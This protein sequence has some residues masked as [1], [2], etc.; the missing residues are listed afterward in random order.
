MLK[1]MSAQGQPMGNCSTQSGGVDDEPAG[2]AGPPSRDGELSTGAA[3]A[4]SHDP[5]EPGMQ[6]TVSAA[7]GGI[8]SADAYAGARQR[9]L[10]T[11][12][13][14]RS[15]SASPINGD[16]FAFQLPPSHQPHSP[17]PALIPPKTSPQAPQ[18]LLFHPPLPE[19]DSP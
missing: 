11:D 4:R 10:R 9:R 19:E 15:P 18:E 2:G 14:P 17:R 5:P 7:S 3:S 8:V 1:P 13:E 16:P 12:R 6:A